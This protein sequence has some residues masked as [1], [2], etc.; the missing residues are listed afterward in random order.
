VGSRG[1]GGAERAGGAGPAANPAARFTPLGRFAAA[2]TLVAGAGCQVI[3]FALAPNFSDTTDRLQ[4]IADNSTRADV[5]KIF[6]VLAMP[7]LLA[8]V[9]VYLLLARERTPRLA[10]TGS[11]VLFIGLVGL[12]VAQGVEVLELAVVRDGR[13][14]QKALA[15]VVDNVSTGAVAVVGAMF[16]GGVLIGILLTIAALW[17]SRAVLRGVPVLMLVFVILDVPLQRPLT[18]H[19]VAL[20]GAAWIA[21]TILGARAPERPAEK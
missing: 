11:I 6:D 16:F 1:V 5:S 18:A 3:A 13:F 14:D 21:W 9:I 17:R 7:F 20:V 15:H 2:A 12:A 8:G 19:I 4:W 10:W